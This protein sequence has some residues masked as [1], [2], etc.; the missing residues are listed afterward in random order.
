MHLEQ[1]L[2]I[3][4]VMQPSEHTSLNEN[5]HGVEKLEV[6]IFWQIK[7]LSKLLKYK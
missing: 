3:Q 7:T 4:Y 2:E 1:D 5:Q 6:Q